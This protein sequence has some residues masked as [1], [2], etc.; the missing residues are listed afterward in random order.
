MTQNI[1]ILC[2][3]RPFGIAPLVRPLEMKP[4]AHL[5]WFQDPECEPCKA[6][7]PVVKQLENEENVDITKISKKENIGL[8]EK[9]GIS[10]IPCFLNPRSGKKVE[11]KITKEQLKSLLE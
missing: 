4:R 5:L 6:M 10:S 7:A 3:K 1:G 11:G 2:F 8:M 9:C